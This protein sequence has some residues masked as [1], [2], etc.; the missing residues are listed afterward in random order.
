MEP[1]REAWTDERLDDLNGRVSDGFGD[2][3]QEFRLVRDEMAGVR[4][5]IGDLRKEMRTEFGAVRGEIGGVRKE[6]IALSGEFHAMQ[7]ILVYGFIGISG[8]MVAG[9][10][11]MTALVATQL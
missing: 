1:V 7:R 6:I 5:E 2:M 4:G 11:S 8:A 3:R 9:F 10:T